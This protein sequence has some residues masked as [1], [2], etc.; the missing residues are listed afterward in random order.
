[1]N[2]TT[3]YSRKANFIN[4]IK[5]KIP[6]NSSINDLKIKNIHFFS[7]ILPC[8]NIAIYGNYEI[9]ILY[10]IYLPS[11]R[12]KNASACRKV[13]FYKILKTNYSIKNKNLKSSIKF[14]TTPQCFFSIY[15]HRNSK[16]HLGL[17]NFCKVY[18]FSPLF[19]ALLDNNN[20]KLLYDEYNNT[21]KGEVSK[22]IIKKKRVIEANIIIAR[23]CAD[24][25]IEKDLAI[26]SFSPPIWK[27]DN[28]TIT[29]DVSNLD[30][31]DENII[32]SGFAIINI[33]YITSSIYYCNGTTTGNFNYMQVKI[34]FSTPIN[35]ITEP[36]IKIKNTDNCQLIKSECLEETHKLKAASNTASGEVVYN[37]VTEKFIIQIKVI[38]TRKEKLYI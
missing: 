25:Y 38:A 4:S 23:G 12:L 8:G 36:N 16:Y 17:N 6:I 26:P 31:I 34:P 15:R 9:L 35:L 14:I 32:A 1:M 21:C 10:N 30:I 33:D 13:K 18:L 11:N 3:L 7:K 29:T 27:I 5:F 20:S 24:L 37:K 2:K 19:I 22:E 28:I